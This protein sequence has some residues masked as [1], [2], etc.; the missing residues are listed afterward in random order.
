M[1]TRLQVVMSEAELEE[2]RRHARSRQ[3]TVSEWVRQACLHA[4]ISEPVAASDRKLA[5]IEAASRLDF[6][7]GELDVL[8]AD[9]ERGYA[10][11]P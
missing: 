8:L 7:T 6:P 3:V 1:S 11:E 10:G 4:R 5:A 9:I 2:I